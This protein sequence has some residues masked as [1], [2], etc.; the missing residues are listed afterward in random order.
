MANVFYERRISAARGTDSLA[1]DIMRHLHTRQHLGKAVVICDQPIVMLS[2]ARKQ[3]LKLARTIQRHRSSTLNADK[4]LKYTH[5]ITRMQHMNFTMREPLQD[6]NADVFFLS[7]ELATALPPQ[8]LTL[9][10][11]IHL[12]QEQVQ[13]LASALPHEA[14]VVDYD[15]RT[16]WNT[17]KLTPKTVLEA[18]VG[19][20]WEQV[21]AFLKQHNIEPKNLRATDGRSYE[22][23]D[24]TLDTLL[25]FSHAF[26]QTASNFH[27][28]L[29]LARPLRVSK[30]QREEYDAVVLLAHRVQALTSETFSRRFLETYNED[31]TLFLYDSVKENLLFDYETLSESINRHRIEGRHSLAEAMTRSPF[32]KRHAR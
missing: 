20:T 12:P 21:L 7:P 13:F 8:C 22:R 3:W 30:S 2:A 31:D 9:Y 15:H 24:D 16:A 4:V 17:Q 1:A 18:Q 5:T 26:L 28:A 25:N 10:D 27:H 32:L 14:L 11:V 6:P 23:M 19:A 29:E